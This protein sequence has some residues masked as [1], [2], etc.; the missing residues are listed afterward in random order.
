MLE[1]L[2]EKLAAVVEKLS[3]LGLENAPDVIEA[4][5]RAERWAGVTQLAWCGIFTVAAGL[6]IWGAT[7]PG[8]E[9]VY[10][11]AGRGIM[12]WLAAFCITGALLTGLVGNPWLGAFDPQALFYS[13]LTGKIL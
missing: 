5:I 13:R 12:G 1:Q 2:D 8:D 3:V 6:F 10:N 7:S 11:P 4:S 9:D